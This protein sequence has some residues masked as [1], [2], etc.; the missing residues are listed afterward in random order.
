MND[1]LLTLVQLRRSGTDHLVV[2]Q[3]ISQPLD[4]PGTGAG[5]FQL[6]RETEKR[7]GEDDQVPAVSSHSWL[8]DRVVRSW[9]CG[10]S[11]APDA[12]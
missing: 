1:G 8:V 6:P 9:A 3:L 7:G 5:R 12:I 11:G 2:Q 10:N 4:L